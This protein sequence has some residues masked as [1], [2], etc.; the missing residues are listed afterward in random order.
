MEIELVGIVG[1]L[2][3]LAQ[4]GLGITLCGV[5][6]SAVWKA[7]KWFWIGQV[8]CKDCKQKAG[9]LTRSPYEK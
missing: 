3:H 2:P 5:G 1:K 7:K 6:L 9:K 4:A 8:G